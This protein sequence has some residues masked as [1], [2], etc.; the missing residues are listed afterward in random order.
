MLA[1]RMHDSAVCRILFQRK[2]SLDGL[3]SMSQ[4]HLNTTK[5]SKRHI[6]TQSWSVLN[7]ETVK[8]TTC[9]CSSC[10]G[11]TQAVGYSGSSPQWH[12]ATMVALT[13][14]VWNWIQS[15]WQS[16]A[17]ATYPV[18]SHIFNYLSVYIHYIYYYSIYIHT[19]NMYIAYLLYLY[20]FTSCCM[21][22]M[23]FHAFLIAKER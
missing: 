15:L 22:S 19:C 23:A 8:N 11:V 2:D 18:A 5:A 16:L 21:S 10:T 3:I 12:A 7:Q 17:S 20:R 9:L 4:T 13:I 6:V 1:S 14:W